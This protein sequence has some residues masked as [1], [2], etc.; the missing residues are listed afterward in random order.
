MQDRN[1]AVEESGI[2]SRNRVIE[3][4]RPLLRNAVIIERRFSVDELSA[5]S[6][7][8]VRAIRSYMAM[9]EGEARQPSLSVALSLAT[10]LGTDAIN[11]LLSLIGY[12]GAKPLDEADEAHPMRDMV[13]AMGA[14]NV[15]AQAA[16]DDRIDHVEGPAVRDAADTLIATF[17]PYSSHGDAE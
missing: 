11:R 13:K 15:F 14:L 4:L 9:D 3:T 8:K 16:V 2:V 6:G 1:N 10:V 7:V 5:L 12:G 17:I